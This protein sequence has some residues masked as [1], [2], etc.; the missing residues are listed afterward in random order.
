MMKQMKYSEKPT[1]GQLEKEISEL[2]NQLKNLEKAKEEL[3]KSESKYRRLFENIQDVYFQVDLNGKIIEISP[4]IQRY[5]GYTRE[6]LIG[7]STLPLYLNPAD[8]QNLLN[9]LLPKGEIIDYEFHGKSKSQKP[10]HGSLNARVI[11]DEKGNPTAFEGSVRDTSERLRV[12]EKL[13][14]SEERYRSLVD[15]IAIGV[16][17]INPDMEILTLNNQMKE[18]F[19]NIDV[20]KHPLCYQ[21]YNDPPAK[22]ICAYCPTIKTLQDGKVHEAV[23]NTP[24]G[25]KT[26]NYRIISSPIKDHEGHIIAVIEM[27]E[28]I[29]GRKRAEEQIKALSQQLL[30][31]QEEERQMI[32]CELHDSVAQDLSVLKIAVEMLFDKKKTTTSLEMR[33]KIAVISKRID[34]S[35]SIVRNL[36]YDL[37][38]PGLNEFG[39]IQVLDMYCEEFST[40]TGIQ[41]D[42]QA[43]GLKQVK[44]D[45]L[46]EIN[47]YRL[48]QEGLLNIRKHARTKTAAVKLVG[49]YPNIILRIEDDGRGF[50]VE[51]FKQES[52]GGRRLGLRS[53]EERVCLLHGQI[54]I[55]SCYGKGTKI[56]INFPFDKSFYS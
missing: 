55:R 42:F 40:N 25:N 30:K 23:T 20:S 11:Y 46:I 24:A 41:V 16:A 32:S 3:R 2:K 18:W 8:R 54:T 14:Q 43:T 35:I 7:K 56:L 5:M 21:S 34:R 37:R 33:Q 19:P 31:A 10:I 13:C 6:E 22:G 28:D 44:L 26:L 29:T 15:N 53:M 50:D 36:S 12:Q 39:L 51:A 1:Y 38:P 49:A 45:P 47:T 48:I 9:E 17:L 4:S 52:G 27:V